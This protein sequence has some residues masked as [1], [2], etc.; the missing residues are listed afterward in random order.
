M[1]QER[2]MANICVKVLIF[3]WH[4]AAARTVPPVS[5]NRGLKPSDG[6]L[7]ANDDSYKQGAIFIS[8]SMINADIT[9][10]RP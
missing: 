9:I 4:L 7:S 10:Y 3:A 5:T 2:E 8:I 6:Q 1:E